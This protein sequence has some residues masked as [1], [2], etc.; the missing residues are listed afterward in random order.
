MPARHGGP[1]AA[2]PLRSTYRLVGD[3]RYHADAPTFGGVRANLFALVK[4]TEQDDMLTCGCI[5][6]S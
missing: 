5:L 4:G 2:E 3:C 1:A 6:A